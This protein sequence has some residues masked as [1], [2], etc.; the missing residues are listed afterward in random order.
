M[1]K[2]NTALFCLF[3]LLFISLRLAA[4]D[5]YWQQQLHYT[6]SASLDVEAKS[7]TGSETLV[8]KNNSPV[9]LNFVWFHLWPNAYKN[10][11]TAVRDCG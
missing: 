3:V 4:Q 5:N 1:K 7:I 11:S 9:P 2:I 6:I 10:D 8:Y